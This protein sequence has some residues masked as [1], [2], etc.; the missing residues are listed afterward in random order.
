MGKEAKEATGISKFY[1]IS[2]ETANIF[3]E[4]VRKK[5]LND[6]SFQFVGNDSQKI[7]IK[8]SKLAEQYEYMLRKHILVSINEKLMTDFDDE[9]I[10]I[11]FEQEIDKITF[12]MET[13]KVKLRKTDINTFASLIKKYG[14]TG[15]AYST[16][17]T[18]LL[19]FLI[20]YKVSLK[21]YFLTINFKIIGLYFIVFSSIVFVFF[22][23]V[24]PG[25]IG[26]ML[27]MAI[28]AVIIFAMY[29]KWIFA[30]LVKQ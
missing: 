3:T 10:N 21:H 7:I 5:V 11:L 14:I 4:I 19:Y 8:I 13:G 9:A 17:I 20:I 30:K 16:V 27:K 1:D 24:A 18:Q 22:K 29:G 23:F 26:L 12:N 25:W 6:V 15:A 28:C 2:D